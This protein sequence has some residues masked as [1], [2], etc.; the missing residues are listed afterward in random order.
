MSEKQPSPRLKDR[1]VVAKSTRMEKKSVGLGVCGGI[2]AIEVV[3][4]TRELRRHGAE[5]TAFFTPSVPA[6]I[7]EL[8]LEWATGK[9]VISTVGAD[10]DHL[11]HYDIVLVAPV[12]FNTLSKSAIGIT[13][14]PVTLL[15]AGQLGRRAPLL[16]V[17]TM[18]LQLKQ[19]PLYQTYVDR[20]KGWGVTF[21]EASPEEDRMK[22][23]PAEEIARVLGELIG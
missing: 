4:V 16:F 17:P 19:H 15:V 2:G 11:D 1:G 14:N 18:N 20:L 10:V 22:M 7:G 12:T 23:P 3:K 8:S 6:F 9:K 5:V 13:D 21:L